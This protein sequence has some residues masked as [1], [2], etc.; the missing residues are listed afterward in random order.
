MKK[1]T[2][3]MIIFYVFIGY[4]VAEN[5]APLNF[6]GTNQYVATA[7]NPSSLK[8]TG[9]MTIEFWLNPS[10]LLGTMALGS[11]WNSTNNQRSFVL[12][13]ESDGD[14]N[15]R[16]SNDGSSIGSATV[17]AGIVA[18][19]PQHVAMTYT[20]S[21]RTMEVY[22]NCLS[23]GVATGTLKSSMYSSSAPF[24]IGRLFDDATIW[25]LSGAIDDYRVWNKVKTG[26]EISANYNKEL[27]G[28]ETGLVAYY[29]FSN[30]LLDSTANANTLSNFG[31]CTFAST[32]LFS[33]GTTTTTTPP[34]TTT[35]VCP[36]TGE[37]AATKS[38]EGILV[39]GATSTTG[40]FINVGYNASGVC[41]VCIVDYN[42]T[43]LKTAALPTLAGHTI[44]S[45]AKKTSTS[46]AIQGTLNGVGKIFTVDFSTATP[47]V[48]EKIIPKS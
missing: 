16:N 6:N 29:K 4:A 10:S 31:G 5:T 38:T 24:E 14:I 36:C 37:M 7:I 45:V 39:G 44:T 42:G 30:N 15:F 12:N 23:K 46:I 17:T 3:F 34:A 20:A 48:T 25:L 33:T 21:T 22:V 1:A 47:T 11:K 26:A 2:L 32:I 9:D 40:E 35:T 13:V 8:I 28:S 18:A 43:V 41:N 19:T 27:T